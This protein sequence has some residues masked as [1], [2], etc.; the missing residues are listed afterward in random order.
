MNQPNLL[1]NLFEKTSH[2][3][4][5]AQQRKKTQDHHAGAQSSKR[6]KVAAV[7]VI[8]IYT[9]LVYHFKII[10][11]PIFG[12]YKAI[13]QWSVIIALKCIDFSQRFSSSK[14]I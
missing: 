10:F 3:G 13:L 8:C 11:T 9:Q 4:T 7:S 6:R 14:N 5:K 2:N 1:W 12:I